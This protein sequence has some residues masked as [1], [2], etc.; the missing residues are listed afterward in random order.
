MAE[1]DSTQIKLKKGTK[2]RLDQ[3]KGTLSYDSFVVNMVSYFETTG[4]TPSSKIISPVVAVKEQASRIIEV[5]RGVE[6]TQNVYLKHIT[7]IVKSMPVQQGTS[8][9]GASLPEDFNKDEYMHISQVQELVSEAESQRNK[10]SDY[11]A[12]INRL[13]TDLEITHSKQITTPST[14]GVNVKNIAE[15]LAQLDEKK[16]TTDRNMSIYE[17]D[18]NFFDK[19][20]D[21][22]KQELK[23]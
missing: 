6:K 20:F 9:Q 8:A 17:I 22:I 7:E 5:I 11:Q 1:N 13:K 23:I 19:Y 16:R 15:I 14:Q 3:L 21:R 18:R 4:L 12:E 2:F 10:I